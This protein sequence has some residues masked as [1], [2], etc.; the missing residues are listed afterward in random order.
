VTA[1]PSPTH[2]HDSTGVQ[3]APPD[4]MRAQ[5]LTTFR[6]CMWSYP[7]IPVLSVLFCTFSWP[8]TFSYPTTELP[9]PEKIGVWGSGGA[10]GLRSTRE[11]RCTLFGGARR[12]PGSGADCVEEIVGAG[13][14]GLLES[15][16]RPGM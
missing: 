2:E 3:P 13:V 15:V 5:S 16:G 9:R 11:H 6:P 10:V 4:A 1:S 14:A 12:A 8:V 7:F